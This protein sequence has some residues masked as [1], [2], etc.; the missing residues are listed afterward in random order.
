MDH[1]L[2]VF[3]ALG[4]IALTIAMRLTDGVAPAPMVWLS[5]VAVIY[6]PIGLSGV[7]NA[8]K[9]YKTRVRD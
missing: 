8:F 7:K 6:L 1:L 3:P 5:V 9:E 4:I 2:F